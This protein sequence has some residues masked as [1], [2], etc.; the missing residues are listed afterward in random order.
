MN[1]CKWGGGIGVHVSNIRAKDSLIRG[2]NGPSSGII[3]MLQVYNSIARYVNQCFIGET[4]IYTDKGLVPIKDLKVGDN[5][6]T[7]DGTLKNI[8][9]IYN[10][11]YDKNVLDIKIMHNFEQ[12]TS[13]TPEHPFLTKEGWKSLVPNPN[14]EPYK[15]EQEP[16]VLKLG[17]EIN[18]NGK[19]EEVFLIEKIRSIPE[20]K[21]YNITVDK[22]HS[23][24]ANGVVVHNK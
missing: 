2:T 8:L 23:Y 15:T 17:D 5:V 12:P 6:Y 16:K 20:E 3:P 13:V 14:Q 7:N 24:L 19:W 22:L 21:V 10:D 1:S 4:K 11:N 18:V 9:K